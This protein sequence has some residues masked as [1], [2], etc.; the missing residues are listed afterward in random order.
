MACIRDFGFLVTAKDYFSEEKRDA[1]S[2]VRMVEDGIP[3]F[4]LAN[5]SKDGRYQIEK[6]ILSD[7]DRNVVLQDILFEPLVGNLSDYAL[8]AL[9]A[10]HLVNSGS[11]NTAWYGD[12]KGIRCYLRRGAAQH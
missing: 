11:A 7:P 1:A 12:Y 6:T 9:V 5:A 2:I 3:A 4:R 8:H 10:P